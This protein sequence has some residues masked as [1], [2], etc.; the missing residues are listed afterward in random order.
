MIW[1]VV[2]IKGTTKM[3]QMNQMN[4]DAAWLNLVGALRI[5]P[6]SVQNTQALTDAFQRLD[7][8]RKQAGL[9]D[10][11]DVLKIEMTPVQ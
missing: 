10:I 11:D 9:P 5:T 3:N 2:K 6:E 7:D 8:T 1:D 4:L